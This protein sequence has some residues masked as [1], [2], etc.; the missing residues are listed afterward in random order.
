MRRD[1]PR[2]GL[3]AAAAGTG[4]ILVAGATLAQTNP[5]PVNPDGLPPQIIPKFGEV[6]VT[7]N[8]PSDG[9][10]NTDGGAANGDVGGSAHDTTGTPVA[11]DAGNSDTLNAMLATS[12]GAT[13]VGVSQQLGVNA[14]SV[15]GVGWA[16]SKFQNVPTANGTS[17]ATGPWQFTTPT[18]LSVSRQY[19]LGYTAADVTD[20]QAQATEVAYLMRDNARAISQAT[21]RPAT[22]L[23]AYGG[24]VFGAT[25]GAQ[26][27]SAAADTPL[28]SFIPARALSNNGMSS[29]TVGQF[30]SV[31]TTR[32][33][34][35]ANQTVLTSS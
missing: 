22:T 17:S 26:I 30:R 23:D 4:C 27:A 20:P 21:G 34:S 14:E 28:R 1:V 32:L 9:S 10:P 15:A 8:G 29:W 3:R 5:N 19:S 25:N 35:S 16:E 11:V 12:Y 31:M 13:A 6:G 33:G 18:F 2:R 7:W 24:W